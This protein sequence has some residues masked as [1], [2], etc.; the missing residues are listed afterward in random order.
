[1]SPP[2][3]VRAS[4][5]M[6]LVAAAACTDSRVPTQPDTGPASNVPQPPA[7]DASLDGDALARAIPGFGGFFIDA[8]GVPTVRLTNLQARAEAERALQP[9]LRSLDL[10][11]ALQVIKADYTAQQLQA[12]V[13][14]AA[15]EVL[16]LRGVVLIDNDEARN[17]VTVGVESRAAEPAVRAAMRRLGIQSEAVVVE[18]T[19]PV[20]EA[21]TLRDKVRPV[22]GGLQI[23]WTS[24]SSAFLCTHGFN[25]INPPDP[26]RSFLTNSH[27]TRARGNVASP[28]VYFQPAPP[29]TNIIGTEVEDPPFFTGTAR[30]CPVGRLCRRSDAARAVYNSSTSLLGRLER[31][32][33]PGSITIA[34][35]WIIKSE[36]TP[37]V[38]Q[39]LNKVGRTTGTSTGK[40]THTCVT[41]NVSGTNITMLCQDI[42]KA[43]VG[44]G[45]SGSPVFLRTPTLSAPFNVRL[46]GILWGSTTIGGVTHFILS[47]MTNIEAELGAMTTF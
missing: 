18:V 39:T 12:W 44:P 4:L 22:I 7:Q 2:W 8:R 17:R 38:G 3:V 1:M 31:T 6:S 40:V 36:G 16:G 43:N 27:C 9:T 11:A 28:T 33:G 10:G 23:Y 35:Q 47:R 25:V 29:N 24:G 34:G 32:T 20:Y 19:G 21:I 14:R 45:D 5:A 42:V 46:E 15:P 30:G 37:V 26:R 13:Q 41:V